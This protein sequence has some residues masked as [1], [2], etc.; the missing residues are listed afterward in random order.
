MPT[1]R[2]NRILLVEDNPVNQRVAQRMLQNLA[3]DV[4]IANNGAEALERIAA[5]QLRCRADGLPDAGHGRLHRDPA[6][7]R[8]GARAAAA[9]RLPIIALTANVMS[10]DR[11]NCIAAGMD[12]HLGKPIE[13]A[14]VIEAVSAAILKAPA[15]HR[16][17]IAS[18]LRELTGGDAEFER[19]L[20]ETFVS[21]G[22]QCLA[23]II[24]A[25]KASDFDTVRKRAH[26]AQG[27]ERQ[28]SC[29]GA[30][31]GR[32]EPGARGAR[33]SCRAIERL[34]ARAHGKACR[35]STPNYARSAELARC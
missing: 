8:A 10:E 15:Q 11:E 21:S 20:A 33:E 23:E 29:A 26:C 6:H 12:A 5:T 13:P 35:P 2:G 34:G 18:A 3:A 28:Y 31:S 17:S 32:V 7:S 24:A 27:R 9:K 19:E 30:Q 1:F 25:L 22:D 4:T 16:R 14:Q